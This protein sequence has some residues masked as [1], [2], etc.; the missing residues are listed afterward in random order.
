M[1]PIQYYAMGLIKEFTKIEID[2]LN[3]HYKTLDCFKDEHS[4]CLSENLKLIKRI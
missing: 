4:E 1:R 3:I 2:L